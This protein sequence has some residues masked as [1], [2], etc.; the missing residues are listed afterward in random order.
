MTP[1]KPRTKR[2][3]RFGRT[4][5]VLVVNAWYLYGMVAAKLRVQAAQRVDPARDFRADPIFLTDLL[6]A[7]PLAAGILAEVTSFSAAWMINVGYYGLS[8]L[9]IL[10]GFL[11]ASGHL[12]GLSEPEHWLLAVFF[13][14]VPWC[15]FALILGALYRLTRTSEENDA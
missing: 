14:A 10:C 4:C 13:R 8:A 1:L 12:F 15:A 3:L 9:Y 2:L 6:W 11:L 5:L 7:L